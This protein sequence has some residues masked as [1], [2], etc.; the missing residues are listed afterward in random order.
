MWATPGKWAMRTK[1]GVKSEVR[2]NDGETA[3]MVGVGGGEVGEGEGEG[4]ETGD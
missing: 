2:P 3:V 1:R 4:V